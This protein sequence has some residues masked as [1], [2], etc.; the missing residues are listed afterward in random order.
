ME[1]WGAEWHVRFG[2]FTYMFTSDV[3][4]EAGGGSRHEP[5]R[6]QALALAAT[7]SS[8]RPA[9]RC[10]KEVML[11]QVK[12]SRDAWRRC[13]RAYCADQYA[14]VQPTKSE[15]VMQPAIRRHRP[16]RATCRE[17]D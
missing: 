13:F 7:I 10:S 11:S 15:A 3:W 8:S 2:G 16:R 5:G 12:G 6:G 1:L 14:P 4:R 9:L 17:P